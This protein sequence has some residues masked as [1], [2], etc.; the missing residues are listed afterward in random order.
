MSAERSVSPTLRHIESLIYRGG[1]LDVR[2]I[3]EGVDWHPDRGDVQ[4]NKDDPLCNP[5]AVV[6]LVAEAGYD[7]G[8]YGKQ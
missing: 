7:I 1:N 2:I 4:E 5:K 6:E 8:A 3:S